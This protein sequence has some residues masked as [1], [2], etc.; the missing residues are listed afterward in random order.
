MEPL[1]RLELARR[2]AAQERRAERLTNALKEILDLEAVGSPVHEI[3][4]D[5]YVTD[6]LWDVRRKEH[7]ASAA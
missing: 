3:A 2:L 7:K 1:S 5:A 6:G 4:L